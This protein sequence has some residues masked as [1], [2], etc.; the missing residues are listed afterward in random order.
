MA[1][2]AVGMMMLLFPLF[3]FGAGLV[4]CGGPNEPPCNNICYVA[5]LIDNVADWLVAISGVLVVLI[6]I[7]GGLILVVSGGN[8]GAKGSAKRFISTGLIGYAILLGAWVIV[9]TL[10][11][12]LIPG[13]SYGVNNPLM[14][15]LVS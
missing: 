12:F 14:C 8:A 3:S 10:L 5:E 7:F 2:F 4:P 13:S 6:I 15:G 11:K 1:R 9:D